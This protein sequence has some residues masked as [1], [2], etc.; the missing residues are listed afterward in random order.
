[1]TYDIQVSTK[2][3][4]RKRSEEGVVS[5][6]SIKLKHSCSHN[7]KVNIMNS[8]EV[9]VMNSNSNGKSEC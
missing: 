4:Q 1:M 9:I 7:N 2:R 3:S 8:N 6:V 5:A